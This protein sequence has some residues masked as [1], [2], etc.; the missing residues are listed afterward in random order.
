MACEKEH[1]DK[2]E[3]NKQLFQIIVPVLK[4]FCKNGKNEEYSDPQ[5]AGS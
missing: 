4:S 5:I 2:T 1:E 3:M